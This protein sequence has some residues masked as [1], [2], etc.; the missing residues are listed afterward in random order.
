[1][2]GKQGQEAPHPI[3]QVAW[4][5]DSPLVPT[6]QDKASSILSGAERAFQTSDDCLTAARLGGPAR[7]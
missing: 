4:D 6:S 7:S 5:G 3:L 1:M 2:S